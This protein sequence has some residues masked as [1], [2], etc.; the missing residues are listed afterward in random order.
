MKHKIYIGKLYC[1]LIFFALLSGMSS[2]EKN[3][4]A[5]FDGIP[6]VS[7]SQPLI[8]DAPSF[9]FINEDLVVGIDYQ[10]SGS[11]KKVQQKSISIT[12]TFT[13]NFKKVRTKTKTSE[14][15]SSF[16]IDI[17]KTIKDKVGGSS[18]EPLSTATSNEIFKGELS[19]TNTQKL[20]T[21]ETKTRISDFQRKSKEFVEWIS[22]NT[23]EY[24]AD[25]GFIRT[26]LK[27]SN[28]GKNPILF[29]NLEIKIVEVD[30]FDDSIE[31]NTLYVKS[32]GAHTVYPSDKEIPF[33]SIPI[34]FDKIS[35]N[36]I[37]ELV[38]NR[39]TL[40]LKIQNYLLEYNSI[41]FIPS[42]LNR[43]KEMHTSTLNIIDQFGDLKTYNIPVKNKYD[44]TLTIK[45]ALKL[46]DKDLETKSQ[47][48]NNSTVEL[49]NRFLGMK[50]SFQ[51]F[52]NPEKYTEPEL[53]Q[54]A[55]IITS[56]SIKGLMNLNQEL[57][58]NSELNIFPLTKEK[59][60]NS[61]RIEKKYSNV[62]GDTD[63]LKGKYYY[64]YPFPFASNNA[65]AKKNVQA[66]NEFEQLSKRDTVYTIKGDSLSLSQGD[67]LRINF[68][69][70]Y[71]N[72]I[73]ET[74]DKLFFKPKVPKGN[75]SGDWSVF[76]GAK[77][78]LK[79]DEFRPFR[80]S[81]IEDYNISIKFVDHNTIY[82]LSE[83]IN[84][85]LCKAKLYGDGNVT[86][87][88]TPPNGFKEL[89]NVPFEIYF[90]TASNQFEYGLDIKRGSGA[91]ASS[92]LKKKLRLPVII[93]CEVIISSAS[94][95]LDEAQ[96]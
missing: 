68:Q 4:D 22:T 81:F 94:P 14:F 66:F 49:I 76:F 67:L 87:E 9:T 13:E 90:T 37:F 39:S 17:S 44:K 78:S 33:Y 7:D 36:Q 83:L 42:N 70:L 29:K 28:S 30:A 61:F 15:I 47:T 64:D 31:K 72:I 38:N 93:K 69:V 89:Q 79:I 75:H 59:I 53:L 21:V 85:G 74:D 45:D 77:K 35:T 12:N 26:G 3:K 40:R 82:K 56:P 62:Q 6:N 32:L 84:K 25:D 80:T 41:E 55:W 48:I 86:I 91:K 27:I 96:D 46:I 54:S 73:T 11:E 10:L 5:D 63:S 92:Y 19:S 1:Y 71:A 52:G 51:D 57:I 65:Q 8:M 34:Q 58:Q 43:L 2:C 24:N 23:I 16:A 88:I 20:N 95:L 18:T 60:W 50:T